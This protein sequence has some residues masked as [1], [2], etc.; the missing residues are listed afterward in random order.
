VSDIEY[1]YATTMVM[2][3]DE[4]L[5]KTIEDVKYKME[6]DNAK[7]RKR[8]I[9]YKIKYQM[10]KLFEVL[11]EGFENVPG[12]LGD[13][14]YIMYGIYVQMRY[15]HTDINNKLRKS[16][17]RHYGYN[18]QTYEY[19]ARTGRSIPILFKMREGTTLGPGEKLY[20]TRT[21][22]RNYGLEFDFR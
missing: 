10:S 20:K 16:L 8:V 7:M 1:D 22:C 18:K 11:E 15:L 6:E 17:K 13:N 2:D 3:G 14:E 21:M 19:Y 9:R 5:K 12:R 4:E